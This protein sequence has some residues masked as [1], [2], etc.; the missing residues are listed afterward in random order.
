VAEL[1]KAIFEHQS[2]P[3]AAFA[4]MMLFTGQP[5]SNLANWKIGN[6]FIGFDHIDPNFN[7]I[8]PLPKPPNSYSPTAKQQNLLH[9]NKEFIRLPLPNPLP[10]LL[11]NFAREG[12]PPLANERRKFF[13]ILG[14]SPGEAEEQLRYFLAHIR[15]DRRMRI[16]PGRIRLTLQ[17]TLMAITADRVL[18]HLLS[19][20]ITD[21][22][23]SAIYYT[24][25]DET[26][27]VDAYIKATSQILGRGRVNE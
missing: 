15:L 20:L 13:Q 23:P 19:G 9:S 16:T 11:Q 4:W 10:S 8:H 6:N 1:V 21:M 2:A 14:V 7:W 3:G 22:P 27:L 25:Y 26:T 24:A 5:L 18:T 12:P 17:T